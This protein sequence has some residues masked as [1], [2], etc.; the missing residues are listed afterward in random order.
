MI[1]PIYLYGTKVWACPVRKID[2]LDEKLVGLIRNMFETLQSA[3]GVGLSATQVGLRVSLAV[4]DI[5]EIKGYEGEKPVVAIN[6]EIL[7][8]S[9]EG[10][11]EEGCLSI[12]DIRVEVNRASSIA[13]RFMDGNFKEVI[14]WLTGMWARVFQHEYDH[15]H[16]KFITDRTSTLKRQILKPS[17]SKIKSGEIF[18]RY[19][20]MSP[21]DEKI[22][23]RPKVFD[24]DIHDQVK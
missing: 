3:D 4:M 6:P 8:S 18:T 2:T 23:K 22:I 14:T 11:M 5:S 10:I 20:V 9:G 12:P 13:V 15:L 24:Y 19:P 17:L 1:L 7:E 16:Q 21:Y